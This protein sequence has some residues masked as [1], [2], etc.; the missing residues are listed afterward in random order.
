[1]I[2][3]AAIMPPQRSGYAFPIVCL[4]QNHWELEPDLPTILRQCWPAYEQHVA[5]LHEF[6]DLAGGRAYAVADHV[7][8]ESP[9]T[10]IMHDLN[11]AGGP[12][13]T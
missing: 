13:A 6:G 1:M 3:P 12:G 7:D 11:G 8:H 5:A 9:P 10:L 4:W 2:D